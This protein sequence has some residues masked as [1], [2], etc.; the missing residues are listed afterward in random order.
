MTTRELA[1]TMQAGGGRKKRIQLTIRLRS[2]G[3]LLPF[4]LLL[5]TA[6]TA[7]VSADSNN[8]NGG[9]VLEA[10]NVKAHLTTGD[11]VRDLVKHPA[12]KGSGEL[13]LPR[14]SNFSD[15]GTPLSSVASLMPYHGN[16]RPDEV[17]DAVNHMID[18]VSRGRKVIYDFYTEQQKQQDLA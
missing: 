7:N 13:L 18:E 14:D 4:F 5:F 16:V 1:N 8:D 9:S 17:L 12:F 3:L 10:E 2:M 11:D 6:C 15:Y